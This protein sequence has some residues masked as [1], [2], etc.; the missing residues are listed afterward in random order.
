M[1]V[2]AGSG[3]GGR[4]RDCTYQPYLDEE[5]SREGYAPEPNELGPRRRME[6][7]GGL[8]RQTDR[9]AGCICR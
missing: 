4:G 9:Q 2:Q 7:Q 6:R 3:V 8:R 1:H 5:E